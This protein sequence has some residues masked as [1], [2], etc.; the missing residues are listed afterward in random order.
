M[1]ISELNLGRWLETI[2]RDRS[3]PRLIPV[4]A[5]DIEGAGYSG[6]GVGLLAFSS[7]SKISSTL[8]PV[9]GSWI[10]KC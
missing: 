3:G 2:G 7:Y 10:L 9:L 1:K 5:F 8:Q 6:S 4:A